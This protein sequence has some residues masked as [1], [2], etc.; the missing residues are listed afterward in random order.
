[1]S[2]KQ[3]AIMPSTSALF[4]RKGDFAAVALFTIVCLQTYVCFGTIA[5]YLENGLFETCQNLFLLAGA[6]FYFLAARRAPE[7]VSRSF[8]LALTIFCMCILFRELEIRGTRYEEALG[9]AFESRLHYVFLG[10]LWIALL[11]GSWGHVLKTISLAPRWVMFGPG[12]ILLVGSVL[13]VLGDIAEKHIFTGDHDVSEMIE[14]SF[15]Q[16]GTLF[17]FFSSYVT[18]RRVR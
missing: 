15:E 4:G 6:V 14:E 13:Y 9:A 2:E 18:L 10:V 8:W 11:V 5:Y 1:M 12:R 16:L 7:A 3:S 17:I